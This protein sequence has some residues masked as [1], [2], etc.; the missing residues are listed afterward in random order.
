M[1]LSILATTIAL[2]LAA[3]NLALAETLCDGQLRELAVNATVLRSDGLR[4][5]TTI[6][7][8]LSSAKGAS[9]MIKH[10]I[11]AEFIADGLKVSDVRDRRI[12]QELPPEGGEVVDEREVAL[13]LTGDVPREL[14]GTI[15]GMIRCKATTESMVSGDDPRIE[16]RTKLVLPAESV[17]PIDAE[18]GAIGIIEATRH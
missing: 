8:E 5:T 1:K 11:R 12:I 18:A 4:V 2:S 15:T 17:E 14:Q 13:L 7:Q 9:A 10:E 16:V 3:N 6:E